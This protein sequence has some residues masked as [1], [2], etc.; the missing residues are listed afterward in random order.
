MGIFA[1]GQAAYPPMSPPA[2]PPAPEPVPSMADPSVRE[3]RDAQ[4]K[5]AAAMAGYAS[6]I[7]TGGLGLTDAASTTASRGKTILGA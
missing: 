6:T 7:T 5:R 3:A 1:G 2:L 4:K